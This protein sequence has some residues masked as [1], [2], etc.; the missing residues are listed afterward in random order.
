MSVS[1]SA[2]ICVL[3]LGSNALT[4]NQGHLDLPFLDIMAGQ[5]R[6]AVDAGWWPV[7]VSSGAVACGMAAMR[8]ESK[9]SAL[10]DRQ[11]LAAIGQAGLAHRWQVALAAHGLQGAQVLLTG[12]DFQDRTRYLNLAATFRSL[13]SYAVIPVIN[14]NDTVSVAELTVG[15]NDRLSALVA[16]QLGA[17]HLLLLTD[18]DGVYDADPRHH[19]AAQRLSE[20]TRIDEALLQHMGGEGLRGRGGMRS[21]LEAARIATRAG[22]LTTIAHAQHPEVL[23]KVLRGENPGTQ[24]RAGSARVPSQRRRWLALARRPAGSLQVDDGAAAALVQ[25]GHSLLAAGIVAVTGEFQ[26]GDTIAIV[27]SQGAELA[28][29]LAGL[30]AQ[31]LIPILGLRMEEA[32]ALAG[33]PLPKAVVHRDNLLIS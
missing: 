25:R 3:K 30:G 20:L 8:L 2:P 19:P 15:D 13:A 4:D 5:V 27:D 10:P 18:I 16:S 29:G 1:T 32:A 23:A 24:V 28:R 6:Q 9:P 17:R 7:V 21:K 26:R 33:Y 14:E 11:A 12:D 31:E 22:V